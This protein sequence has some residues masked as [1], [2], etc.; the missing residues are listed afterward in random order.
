MSN[1]LFPFMDAASPIH[2][3]GCSCYMLISFVKNA[4][5]DAHFIIKVTHDFA[6]GFPSDG[7]W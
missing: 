1:E 6:I 3:I 2:C 7:L 5:W 4:N